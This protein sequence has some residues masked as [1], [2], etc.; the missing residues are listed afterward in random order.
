MKDQGSGKQWWTAVSGA[1]EVKCHR[2][3]GA[4]L[5]ILCAGVNGKLYH[6]LPKAYSLL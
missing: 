3:P 1:S 2:F 6:L 4:P 5:G